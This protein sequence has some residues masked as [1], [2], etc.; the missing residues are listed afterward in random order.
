[1]IAKPLANVEFLFHKPELVLPE[2]VAMPKRRKQKVTDLTPL[3]IEIIRYIA[4]GLSNKEIG[5]LTKYTTNSV[6]T[7]RT[8]L[9]KKLGAV[10]APNLIHKAYKNGVLR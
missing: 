5:V 2:L 8:A 4:D 3:E 9:Y 7:F 6:E 10:N 1:M